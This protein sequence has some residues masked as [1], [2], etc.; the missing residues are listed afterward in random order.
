MGYKTSRRDFFR[1]VGLAAVSAQ[2][3]IGQTAPGA[4]AAPHL[5]GLLNLDV[6]KVERTWL[7]LPFRPVPA[8]NMIREL[9]HWTVFEI[10]RVDLA[11]GVSGF[12]ETM[13][14]YTWQR[15]A[16]EAVRQV[17]GRNA[18]ECMWDD[19]LG[20]GLQMALFDAV[21][22]ANNVP[23]YRLL[24]HLCRNRVPISWWGIDMPGADW[25]SECKEALRQGYTD[26]KT[27]ARPWFDL[28]EQCGVLSKALPPFFKIDFDFNSML[29]D[30][31]RASRYLA[32]IEAFPKSPSS[33]PPFRKMTSPGTS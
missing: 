31:A 15:V 19:S 33:R 9:P 30:G 10:C 29:L 12:G 11:C 24:G 22:K 28:Q 7:S 23:L 21:A 26:F 20:C 17:K 25:V 8:R 16:E 5:K 2:S 32:G 3:V 4:A 6:V 13:P 1:G 18:L 27:K 14:Y